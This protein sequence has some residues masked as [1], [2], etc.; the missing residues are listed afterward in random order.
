MDNDSN[1]SLR[2]RNKGNK[3]NFKIGDWITSLSGTTKQITDLSDNNGSVMIHSD[4]FMCYASDCQHWRPKE[5]DYI[6]ATDSTKIYLVKFLGMHYEKFVCAH[7]DG[8]SE[9]FTM[10]EPFICTLP[11]FL[12]EAK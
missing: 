8:F 3:M 7:L 10:I 5:G 11:R 1:I 4:G 2:L 6:L 9:S 12:K